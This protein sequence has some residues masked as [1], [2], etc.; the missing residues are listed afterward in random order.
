M[1]KIDLYTHNILILIF[2]EIHDAEFYIYRDYESQ[3][4]F[5]EKNKCEYMTH[6]QLIQELLYLTSYAETFSVTAI[7][8]LCIATK[9]V[10]LN[11]V[12]N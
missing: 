8:T 2:H 5:F 6:K 7:E 10:V 9:I 12:V 3:K 4:A 11:N 1:L